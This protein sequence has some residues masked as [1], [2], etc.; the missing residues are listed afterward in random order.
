MLDYIAAYSEGEL[1]ASL[2]P[3]TVTAVLLPLVARHFAG[4]F[5]DLLVWWIQNDMPQPAAE[6]AGVIKNLCGGGLRWGIGRDHG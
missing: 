4:S 1:R 5:L 2:P 3:G 6:M